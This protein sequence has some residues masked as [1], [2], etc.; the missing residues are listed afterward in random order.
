MSGVCHLLPVA[1][2]SHVPC[3]PRPSLQLAHG[4]HGGA[5][6]LGQLVLQAS[7][8]WQLLHPWQRSQWAAKQ[9]LVRGEPCWAAQLHTLWCTGC[10]ALHP[11]PVWHN[12]SMLSDS[13]IRA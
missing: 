4:V 11:K 3:P 5:V 1:C 8:A 9:A 6:P 12:S 10:I 13:R 2:T 7:Q